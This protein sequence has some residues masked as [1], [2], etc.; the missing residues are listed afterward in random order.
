MANFNKLE[1]YKENPAKIPGI[2]PNYTWK[3]T[4]VIAKD[5][6]RLANYILSNTK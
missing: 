4:E 2:V 1:F 5:I 3:S 6:R